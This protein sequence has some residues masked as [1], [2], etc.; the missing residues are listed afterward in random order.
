[1]QRIMKN[2]VLIL[3]TGFGLGLAPVASGTFGS[4]PGGLLI[5]LMPYMTLGPQVLYAVVLMLLAI[6]I[7]GFAEEQLG[8]KDDGRI[9]ADEYLCF[10]IVLVGI[11]WME[12]PLFLAFA[13]VITRILDILKPSPAREAQSLHGGLGIVL[14]DAVAN[15]YA[16]IVNHLVWRFVVVRYFL[17]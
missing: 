3:A 13:F 1:M 11:P 8:R 15:V 10:P 16:L 2:P 14:D 5:L 9:V 7:C 17:D 4:L 12:F 6:P